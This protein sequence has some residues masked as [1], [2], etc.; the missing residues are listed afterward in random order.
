M[1][2]PRTSLV[3]LENTVNKGGGS[4]YTLE[5]IKPIAE[6]CYHKK[7]KLHL[8]G[9]RIFNALA[10]TG[11][12]A[13]DYGKYFDGISVCLIKRILRCA[14]DS[15]CLLADRGHRRKYARRVHPA[16]GI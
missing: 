1:H 8:D 13:L 9:A 5:D 6:L 10:H 15:I 14:G 11:D 7:L 4:C 16:T 12:K 3:V 2:Y